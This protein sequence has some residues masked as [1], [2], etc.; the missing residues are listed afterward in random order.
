LVKDTTNC[1]Q[2][3]FSTNQKH[4]PTRIGVVTWIPQFLANYQSL[5][6]AELSINII[7]KIYHYTKVVGVIQPIK[8]HDDDPLLSQ[9]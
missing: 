9:Q 2:A 8:R 4:N 5:I 6:L 1:S 7:G 3:N